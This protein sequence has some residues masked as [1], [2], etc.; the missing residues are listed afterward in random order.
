M[1][2][3]TI[4]YTMPST[5]NRL[6]NTCL[7]W[8]SYAQMG[9]RPSGRWNARYTIGPVGWTL[10]HVILLSCLLRYHM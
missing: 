6:G 8:V 10:Y 3:L 4:A 2:M 5:L 7:E 9:A 1:L